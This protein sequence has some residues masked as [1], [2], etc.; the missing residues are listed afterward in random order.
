M[1]QGCATL[2][3]ASCTALAALL[4]LM[5]RGAEAWL[6]TAW[7][8]RAAQPFPCLGPFLPAS[9]TLFFPH[10]TPSPLACREVA[11]NLADN[12]LRD[13]EQR[14]WGAVKK[15]G[16]RGY[17]CSLGG[18]GHGGRQG[19]GA[20]GR[21]TSTPPIPS[22]EERPDLGLQAGRREGGGLAPRDAVYRLERRSVST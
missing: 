6:C 9:H 11:T 14:W 1:L 17:M 10:A 12:L 3:L 2:L 20:A 7:P 18:A 16:G 13:F 22:F 4:L 8:T 15:V 5:R 19:T 21:A